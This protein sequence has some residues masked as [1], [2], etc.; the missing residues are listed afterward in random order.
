M[1][2]EKYIKNNRLK[3]LVKPNAKKNEIISFD[4]KRE[5]LRVNIKAPAEKNKANI[6][7]L[8][9]FKKLT[10]KSVS[11]SQGLKSKEKILMIE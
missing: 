7:I 1:N 10:K 11:I 5:A 6:E 3:V 8:K 9:F 2:L 4:D